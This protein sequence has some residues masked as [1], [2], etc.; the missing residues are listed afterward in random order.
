MGRKPSL[1]VGDVVNNFLVTGLL[2]QGQ[3][4]KHR[5]YTV[6]CPHCHGEAVMTSQTLLKSNSCGCIK[7]DSSTWKRK[8]AINKPWKLPEGEA[9][10]NYLFYGYQMSAKRRGILFD[11]DKKTFK[12]IVTQPCH[13]CGSC[14]QTARSN[15]RSN[16]SFKYTGID[17]KDNEEG[18]TLGNSLPCCKVCNYMKLDHSYD[19]FLSHLQK[20]LNHRSN[21]N[22]NTLV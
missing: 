9:A 11:L 18:Y 15:T 21:E 13:Y 1:S 8:G 10:F 17:R 6:T 22:H 16:G 12:E 2:P 4:G 19:D 14:C 3:A 7:K 5:R 20:I